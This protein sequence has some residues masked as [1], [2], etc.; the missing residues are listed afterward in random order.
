MFEEITPHGVLA[1]D[2][3][4]PE[5]FSEVFKTVA[6]LVA[7]KV[8][9]DH[10][11]ELREHLTPILVRTVLAGTTFRHCMMLDCWKHF[12][13]MKALTGEKTAPGWLQ[14][15]SLGGFLCPNHAWL[16]ED[17]YPTWGHLPETVL[18]GIQPR[19][20][21]VCHKP[22][23][24][25]SGP[26]THRGLAMEM[27]RSHAHDVQEARAREKTA[28]EVEA[29]KAGYAA[30]VESRNAEDEAFDGAMRKRRRVHAEDDN[31]G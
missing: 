14:S 18:P 28:Q 26:V 31:E 9:V 21:L 24:W 3:D 19:A 30:Y 6:D 25:T 15:R 16:W 7:R 22:C 27:W 5:Q 23:R 8:V 10:Y 17:H 4:L 12:D 2:F 1:E 13:M 11:D 20:G 29:F